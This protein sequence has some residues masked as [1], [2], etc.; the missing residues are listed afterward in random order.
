VS[1]LA[2]VASS[3][4]RAFSPAPSVPRSWRTWR[5]RRERWR[6]PAGR[7]GSVRLPDGPAACRSSSSRS[8]ATSAASRSTP[9]RGG[10]GAPPSPAAPLRRAGRELRGRHPRGVGVRSVRALPRPA[11]PDRGSLSGFGQTGPWSRRR[12]TTSSPRRRVASCRSPAFPD[13]PPTRGGGSLGDYVQGLFGAIGILAAGRGAPRDGARAGRR[14]LGSGRDVLAP[15]QLAE[16]HAATG[17]LPARNRQPP[18]RHRPYDCYRARDGWV[19]IARRQPTSSFRALAAAIA[20]PELGEDPRF[21]ARGGDSS[22]AEEVNAIVAAWG[23]RAERRGGRVRPRAG[24]RP[25]SLLAR[26]HGRPAPR[27]PQLLAREMVRR[28]PHPTLGEVARS[29]GRGEALGDA[30]RP[31]AA[32]APSSESITARSRG[33]PGTRGD[34]LTRLHDAGV[35]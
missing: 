27:A 4:S 3:T 29:G 9:P 23:R 30:G 2:G 24:W 22:G 31:S 7:R 26:L 25:D 5:R 33:A 13:H 19:V 8:T 1:A 35:I 21:R 28:L 18:P 34:E 16:L 32:S 14:R 20:R 12:P 10:A 17:R 6:R 15:R 11:P